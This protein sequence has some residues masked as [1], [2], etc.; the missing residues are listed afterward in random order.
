MA[1]SVQLFQD[2]FELFRFD[3]RGRACNDV[4]GDAAEDV[5]LIG[6]KPWGQ[7]INQVTGD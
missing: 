3:V 6:R 1:L 5:C 2:F 4:S 7:I